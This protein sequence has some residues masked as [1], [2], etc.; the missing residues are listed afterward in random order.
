[1][2]TVER[3][4][5]VNWS[6]LKHILTS[7]LHYRHRL[8]NRPPDSDAKRLGRLAHALVYEPERVD[9]MFALMPRFHAGMKDDTARTKGYDGGRE[10]KA[11]W[12][13]NTAG[14]DIVTSEQY[15]LALAIRDAVYADPVSG[16]HVRGGYA[17][18][19]I[20]WVHPGTEILC[21]GRVDHVNG[22]LSD[23]KTT[24][25][26]ARF[27]SEIARYI[28][29]A[30]LAWYA[31]GLAECGI[32]TNGPPCFIAVENEP[33]HDVLVLDLDEAAY[34]TGRRAYQTALLELHRCRTTGEWPGIARGKR[35]SVVLP[36]WAQ[37]ANGHERQEIT[38]GGEALFA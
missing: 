24:R 8:L 33:P 4:D 14:L 10:A 30:Q 29:H 35:R 32:A 23:L 19:R 37:G 25:S 21:R 16:E 3:T 9:E 31:D 13:E 12:E 22:V 15:A 1:M 11:E 27:D 20:E 18:Q 6:T 26:L 7:P 2:P 28:Y 5:P 36:A 34:E 17:E 38:I